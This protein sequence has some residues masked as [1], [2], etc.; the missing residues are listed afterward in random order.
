MNDVALLKD[1]LQIKETFY[2]ASYSSYDRCLTG[3]LRLIPEKNLI[4]ALYS[5]YQAMLDAQMFYG[6][7][8]SFDDI[9]ERL[10]TLEIELN[11]A[12]TQRV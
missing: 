11:K 12:I 10:R 3:E 1:V 6:I 9:V 2:R 5:D 7:R 8:L 4:S